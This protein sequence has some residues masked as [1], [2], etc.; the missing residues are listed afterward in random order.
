[1]R[2][3]YIITFYKNFERNLQK[4]SYTCK[5]PVNIFAHMRHGCRKKYKKY[6]QFAEWLHVRIQI[7]NLLLATIATNVLQTAIKY[8]HKILCDNNFGN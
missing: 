1:M 8:N 4:T 6:D 7:V 2:I 5:V 3:K